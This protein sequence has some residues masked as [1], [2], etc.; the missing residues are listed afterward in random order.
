MHWSVEE[1]VAEGDKVMTRVRTRATFLGA[2]LGYPPTGKVIEVRG[3]SVQRIAD[4]RLVEHWAQADGAG[5]MAQ[6][7]APGGAI[8]L[9]GQRRALHMTQDTDTCELPADWVIEEALLYLH[10]RFSSASDSAAHLQRADRALARSERD[11]Q[12]WINAMPGAVPIRR[13]W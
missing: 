1:Q 12:S 4:G 9:I 2:F 8:R 6:L 11:M 13:E 5:F 7:G 10:E 3:V